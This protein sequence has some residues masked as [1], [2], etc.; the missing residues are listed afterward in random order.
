VLAKI[1]ISYARENHTQASALAASLSAFGYDVW[2]D[3]NLTPGHSYSQEITTKINESTHT[4]V[5]WSAASVNS[6]WVTAEATLAHRLKRL[7]P[8]KIEACDAKLPF[9]ALH[10]L[11]VYWNAKAGQFER[12]DTLVDALRTNAP[13]AGAREF[14]DV[15]ISSA[16]GVVLITRALRTRTLEQIAADG[17]RGDVLSLWLHG[18]AL[19]EGVGA[20]KDHARAAALIQRAAAANFPRALN[21][22]SVLYAEGWGLPKDPARGLALLQQA[23]NAGVAMSQTTLGRWLQKGQNGLPQDEAAAF[24]WLHRASMAGSADA[25][26]ALAECFRQGRGTQKNIGEAIHW[27]ERSAAA[28]HGGAL[29][30]LAAIAADG[31]MR[32]RGDAYVIEQFEAAYYAGEVYAAEHLGHFYLEKHRPIYDQR[33]AI[34]WFKRAGDAGKTDAYYWHAQTIR[35][36][37]GALDALGDVRYAMALAA[38]GEFAPALLGLGEMLERGEYGPKD[39]NDAAEAYL[40]AQNAKKGNNDAIK[41]AAEAGYKRTKGKR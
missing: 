4:I 13:A 21:S 40:Q 22:L 37:G 27:L 9:N 2:W 19:L 24:Q 38:D 7:I 39:F 20:Q 8:I 17:E 41:R 25:Q 36:A 1:V 18:T 28:G 16:R 26:D 6:E 5:V 10:T 32:G 30:M 33:L 29:A 14:S 12:L 15:E 3:R 34:A 31:E 23:A 35:E 11:N